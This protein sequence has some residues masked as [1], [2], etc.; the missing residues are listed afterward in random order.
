MQDFSNVNARFID[1][2]A[3]LR[4]FNT[5]ATSA[6]PWGEEGPERRDSLISTAAL[7]AGKWLHT[8]LAYSNVSHQVR[9]LLAYPGPRPPAQVQA[10][11]DAA[12]ATAPRMMRRAKPVQF[13][14]CWWVEM[15][16]SQSSSPCLT[17]S[18]RNSDIRNLHIDAIVNTS[19]PDLLGM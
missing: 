11:N 15:A 5:L 8:T 6:T 12:L 19:T 18:R 9:Q 2:V 14:L 3:A 17:P 13:C 1:A 4:A 7:E 16:G 10:C